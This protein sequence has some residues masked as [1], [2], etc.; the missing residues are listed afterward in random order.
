[1]K[2][3]AE[4]KRDERERMRKDGFVLRQFWVH[5]KDWGLVQKY[6]RRVF[7]RRSQAVTEQQGKP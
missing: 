1:V 2:S 7:K 5:P 6:L 4:R 3:A